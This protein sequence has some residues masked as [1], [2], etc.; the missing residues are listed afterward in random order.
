[1]F[2]V[3]RREYTLLDLDHRARFILEVDQLEVGNLCHIF[4]LKRW[5]AWVLEQEIVRLERL[6]D[7]LE[8][9]S[10]K[11]GGYIVLD[12]DMARYEL[13]LEKI[14]KVRGELCA[15]RL[16]LAASQLEMHNEICKK[17]HE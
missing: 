11:D 10:R 13:V 2:Y 5:R 14:G 3:A 4:L 17:K 8:R 1:M 7:S 6:A 16:E 9:Y 15:A 12:E